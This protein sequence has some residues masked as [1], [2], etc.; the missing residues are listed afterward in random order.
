MNHQP[1]RQ[2]AHFRR[3]AQ[4]VARPR[5]F[6]RPER[7]SAYG[8]GVVSPVGTACRWSYGPPRALAFFRP[9]VPLLACTPCIPTGSSIPL[10]VGLDSFWAIR[11]SLRGPR[12]APGIRTGQPANWAPPIRPRRGHR[13][14]PSDH[15]TCEWGSYQV[16][17]AAYAYRVRALRGFEHELTAQAR[18]ATPSPRSSGEWL[19]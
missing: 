6:S 9:T 10:L 5:R 19:L 17:R 4:V 14:A 13:P 1:R 7:L 18:V 12:P 2:S 16:K 8:W 3:L 11:P 15:A